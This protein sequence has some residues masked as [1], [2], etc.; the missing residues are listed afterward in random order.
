MKDVFEVAHW[1]C[2]QLD[3]LG[4]EYCVIGGVALQAWG[5]SRVTRD[6]DLAVLTGFAHEEEKVKRILARV[7]SRVPFA[8][9]HAMQFRV[10]LCESPNGVGID[11]GLAGFPFE[12]AM[13]NRSVVVEL[14]P[15][16]PLRIA[17]ADDIVVMKVFAGRPRDWEDVE[18]VIARQGPNLD[19]GLIETSLIELLDAI[20]A[21]ERLDRLRSLRDD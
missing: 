7:P 13:L 21:P 5:E 18:G 12:E 11:I 17:C 15:G 19:W 20:G 14:V 9:E 1:V 8:L 2:A 16:V 3:D 10:L 4:F 6:V